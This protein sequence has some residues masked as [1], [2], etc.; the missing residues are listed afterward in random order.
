MLERESS[1]LEDEEREA[2]LEEALA[3]HTKV[4]K[5]TVNKWF[6]FFLSTGVSALA[7]PPLVRSSSST[8]APCKARRCSWS[9]LTHGRKSSATMLVLREGIEHERHG[10]RERGGRKRTE[11]GQAERRSK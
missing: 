11:R 6:F 1:Q 10:D 2:S 4:V 7:R 8:P 3:D 9:A 5:P